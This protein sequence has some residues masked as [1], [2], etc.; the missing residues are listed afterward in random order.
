[1]TVSEWAAVF[2]SVGLLGI[3]A[4]IW[5]MFF[6]Y[7]AKNNDQEFCD[8]LKAEFPNEY[9]TLMQNNEKVRRVCCSF[10]NHS[11]HPQCQ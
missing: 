9:E 4:S 11:S 10:S 2:E 5:Y 8:K 3:L 6:A 7:T 1:M